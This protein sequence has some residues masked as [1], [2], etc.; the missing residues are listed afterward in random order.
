MKVAASLSYV[1]LA[2]LALSDARL[3]QKPFLKLPP[4]ARAHREDAKK[5]FLENFNAYKLVPRHSFSFPSHASN[6]ESSHGAMTI[7]SPLLRASLM[8]GMDG[9]PPLSML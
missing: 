2:F 4:S 7:S 8:E 3:V 5:F 6:P 1:L 9:E